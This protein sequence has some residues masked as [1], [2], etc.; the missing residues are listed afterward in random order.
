MG[1]TWTTD[2]DTALEKEIKDAIFEA[3]LLIE[4]F[5][6][7]DG[8]RNSKERAEQAEMHQRVRQLTKIRRALYRSLDAVA[9]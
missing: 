9:E 6:V 8:P 2:V 5:N 3:E 4:V 7:K 1:V